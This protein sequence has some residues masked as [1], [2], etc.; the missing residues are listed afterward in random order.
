MPHVAFVGPCE[1]PVRCAMDAVSFRAKVL[2]P[3]KAT[4]LRRNG[5]RGAVLPARARR[6]AA[7]RPACSCACRYPSDREDGGEAL[8]AQCELAED[9]RL[10]LR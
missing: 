7:R 9:V 6:P 3:V 4:W 10:D 8:L 1:F 5:P 2:A